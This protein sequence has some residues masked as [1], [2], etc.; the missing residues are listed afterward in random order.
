MSDPSVEGPT[1]SSA[2]L[3]RIE[4]RWPPLREHPRFRLAPGVLRGR[5]GASPLPPSRQQSCPLISYPSP[6]QAQEVNNGE[7]DG[8]FADPAGSADARTRESPCRPSALPGMRRLL[9]EPLATPHSCD[10]H[11]S[12]VDAVDDAKRGLDNLPQPDNAELRHHPTAERKVTQALDRRYDLADESL[13]DVGNTQL[14][15]P[16]ADALEVPDRRLREADRVS[17]GHVRPARGGPSPR[18]GSSLSPPPDP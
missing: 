8:V 7:V 6:A 2:P 12:T 5:C 15:I 17:G 9:H 10:A 14:P 13:T 4:P 1:A 16:G 18:P 3:L 11:S